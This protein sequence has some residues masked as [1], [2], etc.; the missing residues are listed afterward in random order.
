MLPMN[1]STAKVHCHETTQVGFDRDQIRAVLTYSRKS[2]TI[3]LSLILNSCV[4][5]R[6]VYQ[7]GG[8]VS[9]AAC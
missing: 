2:F 4:V 8:R 1:Q 7:R 6:A 3:W 9:A 5:D